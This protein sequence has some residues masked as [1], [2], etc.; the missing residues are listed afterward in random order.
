MTGLA[1]SPGLTGLG[2]PHPAPQCQTHGTFWNA[3]LSG[4]EHG[5]DLL[6][7]PRPS[8]AGNQCSP[9]DSGRPPHSLRRPHAPLRTPT[10]SLERDLR[11]LCGCVC[12]CPPDS[13]DSR[14]RIL[15][16]LPASSSFPPGTRG[17]HGPRAYQGKAGSSRGCGAGPAPSLSASAWPLCL[18]SWAQVPMG[19]KGTS[20][21]VSMYPGPP[22][23]LCPRAPPLPVLRG[24]TL[25]LGSPRQPQA[26]PFSADPASPPAGQDWPIRSSSRCPTSVLHSLTRGCQGHSCPRG[27][28][29]HIQGVDA[30]WATAMFRS[31]NLLLEGLGSGV[32]DFLKTFFHLFI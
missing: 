3:L 8:P 25:R 16:P 32:Q 7:D 12:L 20:A 11:R 4:L 22:A 24:R 17:R 23:G 15:Q 5:G 18:R 1:A 21:K 30:V 2:P 6:S 14:G 29:P 10:L 28:V 19:K 9:Q 13:G 31:L 27:M 26:S